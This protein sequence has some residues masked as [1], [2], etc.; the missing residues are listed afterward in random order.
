MKA[1][2]FHGR[3]DVRIETVDDPAPP[4]PGEVTL[5]VLRAAICGTDSSEWDHG[6][7]LCRPG[8]ILGHEFVGR[9]VA[10]GRD[11]AGLSLGNRVVS[12]AGIS[13]GSCRWC[14][15]RRTNLCASYR[16]LGLQVDGGLAGLVSTPAAICRP[17]PEECDNDAA[18]MAQPFAVALHALT[19]AGVAATDSVAIIGCGG[20]GAFIVAGAT[21]RAGNGRVVAFDI[22]AGRLATARALGAHE[23][24]DANGRDLAELMLEL[25]GGVGFDVVIEAS[26]APHAPAAAIA[27]ARRGGRVLLV[28]LHGAPREIDLTRMTLREVDVFTTVAHVCDSDVPAALSLLTGGVVARIVAGKTIALS[29]LVEEGLRPLAERR[30]AGKILVDPSG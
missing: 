16:T 11:V 4:G 26:G 3:G 24:V 23:A 6:P 18:A 15:D 20:I 27:G 5:E 22:D 25:T 30:A 12:G 10:V 13:C 29:A 1:A 28:G 17:V 7:I 21:S 9:V 2:L 19:R 14:R 8:V